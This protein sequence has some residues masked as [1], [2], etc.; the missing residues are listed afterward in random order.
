MDSEIP[1]PIEVVRV[2]RRS[3]QGV[4]YP[5]F[6]E[7]ADGNL[8]WAKGSCAGPRALCCEWIAGR[9]AQRLGLPLP[10][11]AILHVAEEIV[12][13]S[14][15]NTIADLGAGL[16]FGSCDISGA[17][18]IGYDDSIGILRNH[19]D[20]ASRILMFDWWIQNGDRTLGEKGGNPNILTHVETREMRII[21]HNIAFDRNFDGAK[22]F[23]DH[24]FASQ[25]NAMD[26]AW[27]LAIRDEMRQAY[28]EVERIWEQI[29]DAWKYL[30]SEMTLPVDL[31]IEEIRS[32]L[33]RM[34]TD[35]D[36][37]WK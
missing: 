15:V 25:R 6:C 23:N 27:L 10:P 29:P 4:T 3:T 20:M 2:I 17:Q 37:V 31:T 28:C 24:V 34:E 26:A 18:E 22:F 30:D 5:F 8:Y 1:H 35:W 7:G 13:Y 11:I 19:P 16:V 9:L 33:N 36:G 14:L 12:A 32:I 21:D